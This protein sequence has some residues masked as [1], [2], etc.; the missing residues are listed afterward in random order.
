MSIRYI[1]FDL[2]GTLLPMDQD[3]FIRSYFSRLAA[4]LAPLGYEP[5]ALIDAIWGGTAA[6]VKNN[7]TATNETVFWDYFTTVFGEKS[8][9]DEP[10]FA[11]F[12]RKDFQKVRQSCGYDPRAAQ[13]IT[14]IK[15]LGFTPV[16]ATNPIFP[17][18]A[19]EN[20]ILC[21]AIQRAFDTEQWKCVRWQRFF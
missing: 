9:A 21:D 17:A 7:G 2:D 6:M 14:A 1:L 19:T 3:I 8:R 12:Y 18:V 11:E 15:A 5:K 10:V 4:K 16:L 13:I 20:R